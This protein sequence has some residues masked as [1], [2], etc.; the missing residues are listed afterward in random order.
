MQTNVLLS[1]QN[2]LSFAANQV[3]VGVIS[4][5]P[6]ILGALVVFLIGWLIADWLKTLTTKIVN[7]TRLGSLFKNPVITDFL[8]NAQVSQRFEDVIGEIVK[9]LVVTLFF[10]AGI[11]ILGITSISLFLNGIIA[12]IPTLIAA[13]ITLVIGIVVAGF[14]EKVVKGSLG[15]SDPSMSRLVGKVVS[16]AV[17]TF[18]ILAALS[19]LG[20]ATFFINTV[21]VGFIMAIALALGLSLGLGA[22]DITKKVLEDWYKKIDKQ[23]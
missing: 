18:F 14:L 16:Y 17:M 1:F 4:F 2:S 7:V 6:N 22:K 3:L 12:G 11:N 9:W 19:Q 5:L 20:I 23:G 15:S 10:V 21:F 13:V 8:K